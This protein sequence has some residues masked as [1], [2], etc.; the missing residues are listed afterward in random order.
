[1]E[2]RLELAH[3]FYDLISKVYSLDAQCTVFCSI[4]ETLSDAFNDDNEKA[5]QIRKL[6]VAHGKGLVRYADSLR[7]NSNCDE[8]MRDR[9]LAI[10]SKIDLRNDL[11]IEEMIKII[12][13]YDPR[14]ENEI[15]AELNDEI[16][17]NIFDY[18]HSIK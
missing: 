8:K 11:L 1:M 3:Y 17:K 4:A 7:N 15:E 2:N 14:P 16:D 10:Q 12:S 18:N 13:E 6:L 9:I 5:L